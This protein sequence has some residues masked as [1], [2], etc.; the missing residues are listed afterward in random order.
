MTDYRADRM[1]S[2]EGQGRARQ[3]WE[4]YVSTVSKA[5]RPLATK[6]ATNKVEGLVG[7][8]V[9][10]HAYGGFEN[11]IEL[12]F[13]PSSVHRRVKAFRQ[14]FGEH[15]DTFQFKGLELDR[16]KWHEQDVPSN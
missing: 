5:A 16:A 9:L 10:W 13:S 8:W 14:V 12:G 1:P 6:Y 3:A 2:A 7:F 11:L 15:P 4:A